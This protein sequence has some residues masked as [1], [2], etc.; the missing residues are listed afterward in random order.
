M[1]EVRPDPKPVTVGGIGRPKPPR[2]QRTRGRKVAS[3][4]EWVAIIEAKGIAC[5]LSEAFQADNRGPIE[6]H[7]L[8]SRAQMG[9]DVAD[10]IVPLCRRCHTAVT[11]RSMS[12]LRWLAE[13]LTDAEYAYVVGKLGEGGMQRLFGVLR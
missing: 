9:D 11:H 8:V 12:H 10:N 4:K 1:S 6:F 3:T 5:R 7:H 13:S 2:G